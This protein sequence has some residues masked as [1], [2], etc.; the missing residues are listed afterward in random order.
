MSRALLRSYRFR[1]ERQASWQELEELIERAHRH[2]LKA[3][4]ADELFRLPVLYRAALSSLAVAREISL[5]K[6]VIAY[7]ESLS[8]RAY[9]FV[10]GSRQSLRASVG[11]FFALRYPAL[12]WS[13]R[14]WIGVATLT[15]TLGTVTGFMLTANDPEHFYSLVSEEM[16]GGR[17]PLSSREELREVLESPGPPDID[18]LGA[19]A[20]FLFTHNSKIGLSCFV[21]GLAAGVPVALLVFINGLTLGAFAQLHASHDLGCEFWAWTLP[22][23]VTELLAVCLCAGAG[24]KLGAALVLPGRRRRLEAVA[25]QG[26]E[27]ATVVVGAIALF[28]L[29]ALI[30]GFLRQLVVDQA[31]RYGVSVITTVAWG[32]YF[33]WW[34]AVATRRLKERP[35]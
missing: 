11:G 6:N 15:L 14:A 20:S 1:H 16:A 30:E 27:S 19:F 21:A 17:S 13:M 25:D 28:L 4:D 29:A 34:G 32:G 22:H 10:Y 26:R 31:I 2:G 7:L 23:G 12:V 9:G 5:D 18:S 35:R 24:L 8:A 33:A 3:L